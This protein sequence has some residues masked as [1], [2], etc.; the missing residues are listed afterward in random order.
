[1]E[2]T[3]KMSRKGVLPAIIRS[4][5]LLQL[6]QSRRAPSEPLPMQGNH[7][8]PIDQGAFAAYP[9]SLHSVR[10]STTP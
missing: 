10:Y 2:E 6:D 7:T 9:P 8:A 5:D 3:L 4:A 1:M